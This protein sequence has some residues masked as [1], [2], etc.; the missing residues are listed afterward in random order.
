MNSTTT[1]T[2]YKPSKSQRRKARLLNKG[3]QIV[4]ANQQNNSGSNLTR[5]ARRRSNRKRRAPLIGNSTNYIAS[6]MDPERGEG[7][8]IPDMVAFPSGTIQLQK[9]G[10]IATGT[11]AG[12]SVALQFSPIIGNNST[13]YPIVTYSGTTVNSLSNTAN[14]SWPSYTA[15]T[16]AYVLYRPVSASVEFYFIGNSTTDGGR[17][18]GGCFYYTTPAITGYGDIEAKPETD[19]WAMRNGMKVLWKPIDSSNFNYVNTLGQSAGASVYYPQVWIAAT[20]L[21]VNTAVLGYKV[22]C[23]FECIP[24]T[25]FFDVVDTTPSPFDQSMLRRAFEWAAESGNNI[26][27]IVNTVGPYVNAG[28]QAS[29]ALGYDPLPQRLFGNRRRSRARGLSLGVSGQVMEAS[30]LSNK[31][32]GKEEEEE[33]VS[34]SD[35]QKAMQKFVK[36]SM[37]DVETEKSSSSPSIKIG[38]P[39]GSPISIRKTSGQD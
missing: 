5:K 19:E 33:E 24:Q 17:I 7:S 28:L 12:D 18:C 11:T 13:A 6:L 38:T 31:S 25:S 27:S 29:R 35:V 1:M 26:Q 39:K 32:E 22:V 36:L 20:G 14:V 10:T 8:K 9:L 21:P 34:D 3:K 2:V 15:V 16:S 37:K 4:L 23:N 30:S